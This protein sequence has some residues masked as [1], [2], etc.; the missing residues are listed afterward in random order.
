MVGKEEQHEDELS[1]CN[2]QIRDTVI[3]SRDEVLQV[4]TVVYFLL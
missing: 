4:V 1:L 2:E 3:L